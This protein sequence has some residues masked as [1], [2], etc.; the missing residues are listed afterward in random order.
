MKFI[1]F[2]GVDGS[3]KTSVG[4]S[5]TELVQGHYLSTPGEQFK[6]IRK[7][8]NLCDTET[9][10]LFYLSSVMDAS[11]KIGEIIQFRDVV[12]D[13]YLW[14]S[15]VSHGVDTGLGYEGLI[16]KSENLVRNI[17][18]PDLTVLLTVSEEEQIKRMYG[19]GNISV[20][21]KVCLEDAQ[22]RM[23]FRDLYEDVATERDWFVID[24]TDQE[25]GRVAV[26]IYQH[27]F[28]LDV[29]ETNPGEIVVG[30]FPF[31]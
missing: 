1:A 11:Q 31:K 19:R 12:C 20:N 30:Q 5:L 22:H 3:G 16:L 9:K 17:R 26:K 4:Q 8:I 25:A 18:E 29:S 21:D 28:G 7:Y 2:E 23:R 15:L 13:R 27:L 10:F 6:P 24:T 14:S